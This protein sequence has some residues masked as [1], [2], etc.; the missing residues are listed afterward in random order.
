MPNT[1]YSL[2]RLKSQITQTTLNKP[3]PPKDVDEWYPKIEE[4]LK[5]L[6]KTMGNFSND[7]NLIN[8]Q[9]EQVAQLILSIFKDEQP[10]ELIEYTELLKNSVHRFLQQRNDFKQTLIQKVALTNNKDIDRLIT[11][12]IKKFNNES[13]NAFEAVF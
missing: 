7:D 8:K 6:V 4:A 1:P 5:K 12:A 2:S 10:K 13:I 3:I 9:T 11:L